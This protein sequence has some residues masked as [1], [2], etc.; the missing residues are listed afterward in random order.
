MNL[1]AISEVNQSDS[2]DFG[3]WRMLGLLSMRRGG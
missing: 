1:L 3:L 2:L